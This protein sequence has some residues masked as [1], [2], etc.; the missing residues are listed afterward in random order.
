MGESAL[1]S[2]FPAHPRVPVGR[3]G[4]IVRIHLNSQNWESR[5]LSGNTAQKR[6]LCVRLT[7]LETRLKS[8]A[9]CG[10]GRG[11]PTA[12]ESRPPGG[13]RAFVNMPDRDT[14]AQHI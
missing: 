6:R 1:P 11:H 3:R 2:P 13:H 8:R 4:T 10:V 9:C 14:S 7:V 5:T 12:A